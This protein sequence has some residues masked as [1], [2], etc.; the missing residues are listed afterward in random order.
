VNIIPAVGVDKRFHGQ[1]PGPPEQRYASLI[2]RD[3]IYEATLHQERDPLLGLYV[4]PQNTR[5][6]RFYQRLGFL[7][8]FRAYTDPQT[9]V[10]YQSMVLVLPE[11]T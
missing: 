8:F 5:A 6:I 10:V 2:L 11:H 7:P 4:H 9:S 3:L 1:P